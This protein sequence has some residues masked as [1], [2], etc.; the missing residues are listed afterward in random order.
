MVRSA[1]PKAVTY[2]LILV[3]GQQNQPLFTIE[4]DSAVRREERH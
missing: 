2:T 3:A 1:S 4:A